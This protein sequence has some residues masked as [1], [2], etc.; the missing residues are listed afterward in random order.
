MKIKTTALAIIMLS[1]TGFATTYYVSLNGLDTPPYNSWGTAANEI[2][3]AVDI[4]SAGDTV[5]VYDGTYDRGYTVTPGHTSNNRLIIDKDILVKAFSGNPANTI[6]SGTTTGFPKPSVN[7]IR[8]VYMTDGILQ[9]F[10][11]KDGYADTST[12]S[13][14]YDQSGGGVNLYDGGRVENCVITNCIAINNGGGS[15]EGTLIDCVISG[16]TATNFGG[17][18]Y[19]GNLTDCTLANNTAT[20]GGGTSS[21]NATDCSFS[22]NSADN[23]GGSFQGTLTRCTFSSNSADNGGGSNQGTLTDCTFSGNSANYGGGSRYGALS[24]CIFIGNTAGNGGGCCQSA[25]TDCIFTGNMATSSGGGSYF[26]TLTDCTLSNNSAQDGGGNYLGTLTDC[27]LTGNSASHNGGGTRSGTLLRCIIA[28]NTAVNQGGG[29]DGGNLAECTLMNNDGGSK[30]GGGYNASLNRCLISD[31]TASFGGG[32]YGFSTGSSATNCIVIG[33]DA[34]WGGGVYGDVVL[35]N[36]TIKGNS[37]INDGGGCCHG[38]IYNS[39]IVGNLADTNEDGNGSGDDLFEMVTVIASCTPVLEAGQSGIT[40]DPKFADALLHLRSD[41]P[42]IDSGVQQGPIGPD[43]DGL[44]RPLDGNADGSEI[45]DMGAHEFAGSADRDNDGLTDAEEVSLGSDLNDSDTDG[46]GRTDGDEV[47]MG[48]SPTYDEAPAI[49]QGEDN[50]T[51]DPATH[52][53]YTADS[54]QDLNMGQLM[55]QTSGNQLQLNLQ[56]KQTDNLASNVWSDAG[57]PVEWQMFVSNNA[58]FFRVMATPPL[59]E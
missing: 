47:A 33:N 38:K 57:E 54:I 1:S 18:C 23:G 21:G 15:Y 37:A 14:I 39:I 45:I 25:V 52:G 17:G 44:F 9:G 11:L 46:D 2:Q 10:T 24:Q 8:C 6:I 29:T 22:N 48:F 42:C 20:S 13:S 7:K 56:M 16:N 50:V 4:A 3:D 30:G 51:G 12:G 53:L 27:L 34:I 28:E 19:S 35:H 31:N 36:C 32:I 55:V 49:A 43:F 40:D 5:L 26:S 41:S 58:A 59:S